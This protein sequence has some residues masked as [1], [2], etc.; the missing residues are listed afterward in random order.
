MKGFTFLWDTHDHDDFKMAQAEGLKTA[1]QFITGDTV[2]LRRIINNLW[3]NAIKFTSKNDSYVI[4][5]LYDQN[6]ISDTIEKTSPVTQYTESSVR[7][8]SA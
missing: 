3:S 7:S 6:D 4:P 1:F 5:S 2:R 8:D